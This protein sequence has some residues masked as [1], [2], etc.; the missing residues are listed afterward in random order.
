MRLERLDLAAAH[1]RFLICPHHPRDV[2]PVDVGIHEPYA[3]TPAGQRDGEVR[4]DRGFPDAAL[5]R[6]DREDLAEMRQLDGRRGWRDSAGRG[7]WG[8]LPGT[9][10]AL[11]G[12]CIGDVDAHGGHTLDPLRRL[13][14]L[15]R[16]RAWVVA[17]EEE[18]ER[19]RTGVVGGEILDHAARQDVTAAAQVGADDGCRVTRSGASRRRSQ[20]LMPVP[21]TDRSRLAM[22]AFGELAARVGQ[23]VTLERILAWGRAEIPVRRVEEI[24]TQDEF[25]HDVLVALDAPLYLAYDVT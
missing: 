17:A 3:V 13:P 15:A 21:V 6:R 23:H 18:R 4:G 7:A 2:G 10:A 8:T 16:E 11:R 12:A 19:D 5:A 24:V 9:R 1:L 25:T 22:P 14:H 20:P